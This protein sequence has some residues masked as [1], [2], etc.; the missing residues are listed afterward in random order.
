MEL[1]ERIIPTIIGIIVAAV[2]AAITI[3]VADGHFHQHWSYLPVCGARLCVI[4][5]GVVIFTVSD[6]DF[7]LF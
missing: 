3:A 7:D 6:G 4:F 2:G 1:G 5:I